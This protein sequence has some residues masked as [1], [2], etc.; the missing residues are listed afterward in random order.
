MSR[1][2][3]ESASP[4][5]NE[6]ENQKGDYDLDF[7]GFRN[8]KHTYWNLSVDALYKEADFRKEG[9]CSENGP[10]AIDTGKFKSLVVNDRF[11]VREPETENFINWGIDNRP[12][13]PDKFEIV[14]YRLLGFLQKRDLFVQDGFAG[15]DPNYQVPFRIITEKAWQSLF[16]KNMMISADNDNE[17]RQFVPEFT[18][19]SVPSFQALPEIDGTVSEAFVIINFE[20]KLALIGGTA[21][22]GEIKNVISTIVNYLLPRDNILTLNCAANVGG[23]NDSAL[24][25]GDLGTGKTVLTSDPNR[26]L[27]GDGL[28]G[29]SDEG[30]FNIEGGLYSKLKSLSPQGTPDRY[31]VTKKFGTV[32]E[33]AGSPDSCAT[34]SIQA[35]D[36]VYK[37]NRADHP[38]NIFILTCDSFGLLPPVSKLTADQAVYHFMSGYSARFNGDKPE[39]V[40]NYCFGDS[41][42]VLPPY[43][44]AERLRNKIDRYQVNCWLLNTGWSGGQ[45]GLRKRIDIE[46]IKTII[47]SVLENKLTEVEFDTDPVFGFEIPKTCD[48]VSSDLLNPADSWSDKKTYRTHCVQLAGMYIENFKKFAENCPPE[49]VNA[50]PVGADK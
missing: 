15:A 25:F 2:I 48:T 4:A 27:L 44:Y 5:L 40:F 22:A 9:N 35:V 32:L 26:L 31:A 38:K 29:W 11:I 37:K 10:M 43:F 21:F 24:F 42:L 19:L 8:L 13:A 50:G 49:I 30:I 1:Q 23:K 28:F 14:Y 46:T 39:T 20:R 12:F 47:N 6:A 41:L 45:F 17:L 16:A 7:L 34:C 18:I 33:N 36:N 3:V